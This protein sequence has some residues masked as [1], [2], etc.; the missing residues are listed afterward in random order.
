M[1]MFTRALAYMLAH[2]ADG[3]AQASRDAVLSANIC[4][5][6]AARHDDGALWRPA[7]HA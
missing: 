1:G 2:G 6:E 7:L 3:L 5:R 4:A